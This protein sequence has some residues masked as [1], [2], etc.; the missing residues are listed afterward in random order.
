VANVINLDDPN[1]W[2]QACVPMCNLV[3]KN[4]AY[5]NGELDHFTTPKI[6]YDMP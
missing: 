2:I 1:V 5:G 6:N 3:Q 4:H